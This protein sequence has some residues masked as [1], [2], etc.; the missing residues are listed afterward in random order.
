MLPLL[1]PLQGTVVESN[2]LI[3]NVSGPYKFHASKYAR[4]NKKISL[5]RENVC[6]LD[7]AIVSGGSSVS[8]LCCVT[9]VE[10]QLIEHTEIGRQGFSV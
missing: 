8:E 3:A 5:K 6:L 9:A 1:V 10:R 4:N 2:L 7:E